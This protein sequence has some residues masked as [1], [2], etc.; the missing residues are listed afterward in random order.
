MRS[1]NENANV[2]S[3]RGEIFLVFTDLR[4]IFFFFFFYNFTTIMLIRSRFKIDSVNFFPS[5]F[6]STLYGSA[7]VVGIILYSTT[8]ETHTVKLFHFLIDRSCYTSFI[9]ITSKTSH[10]LLHYSHRL[11]VEVINVA[12]KIFFKPDRGRFVKSQTN[13][14]ISCPVSA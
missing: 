1:T 13:A 6:A 10:R 2:S 12:K 8:K 14:Y 4:E 7:C 11:F 3:A 5:H 9:Y